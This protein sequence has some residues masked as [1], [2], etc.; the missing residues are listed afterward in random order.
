VPVG[1]SVLDPFAGVG[2]TLIAALLRGCPA[3]GIEI[4]EHYC[5]IA[6]ERVEREL[7]QLKLP[8]GEV[9]P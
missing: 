9:T 7:A 3:T 6:A 4:N 2:T 1:A 5:R 8:L